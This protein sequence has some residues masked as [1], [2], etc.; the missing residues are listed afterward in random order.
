MAGVYLCKISQLLLKNAFFISCTIIAY[1]YFRIIRCSK[2]TGFVKSRI[3]E[4]IEWLE[5][6]TMHHSPI[7]NRV[8]SILGLALAT[9]LAFGLV[10]TANAATCLF[11]DV[12]INGVNATSCGVG[13]TNND[14]TPTDSTW[15]V[16]LDSAGG[17]TDWGLY[18]RE[19]GVLGGPNAH[20]G[21]TS[22]INLLSSQISDDQ[23][24]GTMS[25]NVF[26]PTLITLKDGVDTLYN[27]YY[28]EGITGTGL[29]GTWDARVFDGKAL[30]TINA[31]A[32]V[33][34]PAAVWLFGSGLLGLVGIAKRK[35][36]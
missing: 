28:F 30:S 26:D 10:Q 32:V 17:R 2:K 6:N 18:E 21:N 34:V 1:M 3:A 33:P 14:F 23:T 5:E 24:V 29:T 22:L 35:K 12:T 8:K 9:S 25:L 15:Q 19:E 16:N 36:A 7:M 31:Y 11:T 4:Y 27:W 20:D 13:S